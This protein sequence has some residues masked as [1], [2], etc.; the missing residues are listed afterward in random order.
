MTEEKLFGFDVSLILSPTIHLKVEAKSA[1]EAIEKIKA[2][3]EEG[4]NAGEVFKGFA[5][6][7]GIA[8]TD[9]VTLVD[10][11]KSSGVMIENITGYNIER[12]EYDDE[13]YEPF[14]FFKDW[15]IGTFIPVK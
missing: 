14:E 11:L 8:I 7:K 10:D 5:N 1:E 13:V 9:F 15:G 3:M 12:Y 4:D 6:K 2:F